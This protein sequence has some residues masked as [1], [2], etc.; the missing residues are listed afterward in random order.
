MSNPEPLPLAVDE[1]A[2]AKALNVSV[3][4]LRKDRR[5]KRLI[6][7]YRLGGCVRYSPEG[8]RSALADLQ[9]GGGGPGRGKRGAK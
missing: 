8:I 9:E 7:F 2:A 3:A 1:K 4:W 6:P 5:T